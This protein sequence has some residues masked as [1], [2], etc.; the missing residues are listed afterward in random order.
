ME[1]V[2]VTGAIGHGG[3]QGIGGRGGRHD[4]G[5]PLR[6]PSSNM[7][8]FGS[9]LTNIFISFICGSNKDLA[10]VAQRTQEAVNN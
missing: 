9:A 7:V 3:K 4:N 6:Q 5:C 1:G 2:E 10:T 8:D